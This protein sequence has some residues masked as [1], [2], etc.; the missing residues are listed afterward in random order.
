MNE[1]LD[2]EL[3]LDPVFITMQDEIEYNDI[4]NWTISK[5]KKEI[6][7]CISLINNVDKSL[8]FNSLYSKMKNKRKS[9]YIDFLNDV[10]NYLEEQRIDISTSIGDIDFMINEEEPSIIIVSVRETTMENNEPTVLH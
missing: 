6:E 1:D 4:N 3:E 2:V 7:N 9:L 8:Q 10:K 5:L